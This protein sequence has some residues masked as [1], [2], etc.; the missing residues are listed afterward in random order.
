LTISTKDDLIKIMGGVMLKKNT[1]ILFLFIMAA[2]SLF[3][4][5]L[6]IRVENA[7]PGKGYLM[8]GIF[9]DERNFPDDYFKGQRVMVT[10]TITVIT[11]TDLPEGAYAVSVYQDTN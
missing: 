7:E 10:D 6:T 2:G 11:F 8:V 5:T 9:N 3:A 4:G 1:I